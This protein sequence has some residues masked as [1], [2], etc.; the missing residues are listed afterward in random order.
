MIQFDAADMVFDPTTE[1][2]TAAGTPDTPGHFYDESGISTGT[3]RTARWNSR[4]GSV[5]VEE[6]QATVPR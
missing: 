4:T 1:T 6:F 5:Q 3:F 2:L